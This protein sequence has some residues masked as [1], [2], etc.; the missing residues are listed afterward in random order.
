MAGIVNSSRLR[1]LAFAF[2]VAM[3]VLALLA[4]LLLRLGG[5]QDFEEEGLVVSLLLGA[6]LPFAAAT[7]ASLLIMRT[8]RTSWRHASTADLTN[9]VYAVTLA[10]LIFQPMGFVTSRLTLMPR[11]SVIMAWMIL[12]LLM[13]GSRISYRLYREGRLFFSRRPMRVGQMPILIVGGGGDA[14]IQLRSLDRST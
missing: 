11:T 3:S 4:G 6:I 2:D 12:I 13:A 1:F 10:V 8:Y 5:F 7:G 14:E 9:I